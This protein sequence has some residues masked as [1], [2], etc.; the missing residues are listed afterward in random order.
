MPLSVPLLLVPGEPERHYTVHT[1]RTRRDGARLAEHGNRGV[2]A[3]M[4]AA[5][6]GLRFV[7]ECVAAELA[8]ADVAVIQHPDGVEA[9]ACVPCDSDVC[10]AAAEQYHRD[11]DEDVE[12]EIAR[13]WAAT[14]LQDQTVELFADGK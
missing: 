3:L 9:V 5:R 1:H 10:A 12:A 8:D 6:E 14:Q 4:E 13:A 11:A 7:S 2:S